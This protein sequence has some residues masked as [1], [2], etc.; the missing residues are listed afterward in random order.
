MN[1]GYI[2]AKSNGM[3]LFEHTSAVLQ[4]AMILSDKYKGDGINPDVMRYASIFHDLGKANP[5]FQSNMST[6]NFENVCR[7][8]ISSILFIDNIQEPIRDEV[9]KII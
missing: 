4:T 6:T 5:L 9:A 2:K 1:I 7:H 8:E 3:S